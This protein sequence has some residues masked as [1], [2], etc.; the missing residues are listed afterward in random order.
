MAGVERERDR[1]LADGSRQ[2]R[3]EA[4]LER[5]HAVE[6]VDEQVR[7][8]KGGAAV[9]VGEDALQAAGGVEA[10][11]AQRLGVGVAEQ[12]EVA[13]LLAQTGERRRL[14]FAG[15]QIEQVAAAA[16]AALELG[17]GA[18]DLADEADLPGD[19]AEEGQ[20]VGVLAK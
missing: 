8:A 13:R 5:A 4:T 18:V 3:H 9:E 10:V 16:A 12:G 7:V 20:A 14:V 11:V 2:L 15:E 6:A 1:R 19:A 17:E